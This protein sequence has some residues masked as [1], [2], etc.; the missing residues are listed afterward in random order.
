MKKCALVSILILLVLS[1]A[2]A[3]A[4]YVRFKYKIRKSVANIVELGFTDLALRDIDTHPVDLSGKLNNEQVMFCLTTNKTT[5]YQIRLTFLP[6]VGDYNSD[7]YGYYKVRVL[8]PDYAPITRGSGDNS[9]TVSSVSGSSV[10]FE[11]YT[12]SNASNVG[13]FYYPISFDFSD[14]LEDYPADDL[15]G[16]IRVE[17]VGS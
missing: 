12:V 10:T 14:Y 13:T 1:C 4:E 8:D 2:F 15:T 6:L 5:S 7:F 9:L 17:V 16:T 11:G 3:D